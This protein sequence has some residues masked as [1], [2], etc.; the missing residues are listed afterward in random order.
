MNKYIVSIILCS[1]LSLDGHSCSIFY[2]NDGKSILAGN[3]EDWNDINTMIKFIPPTADKYGYFVFGLK[4]WG[5]DFCSWGGVN[6]QGVFYDWADIGT[7]DE[8][9][10]AKGTIGYN[11][12]LADKMQAECATVDEAIAIFKKYNCPGLG[13]AHILIGDRFGNSVVIEKTE[14]D[15]LLFIKNTSK[16]QIAT[17]FLNNYLN[18]P[19]IYRWVQCPRYELI[20]YELTNNDTISI[21]LFEK[22]LQHVGN[23]NRISPS[24]YSNIYDFVSGKMYIYNY[25]NFE[26]VLI[27]DIDQALK[28]GYQFYK[29][30]ELFSNLRTLLPTNNEKIASESVEFKWVGD[31]DT[32]ELWISTNADFDN[33]QIFDY[34]QSE[35]NMAGFGFSPFALLL[36]LAILA[37]NKRRS[38]IICAFSL[39]TM[40]G[41]E[42]YMTD[43]P[44][45]LSNNEHFKGIENLMPDTKYYWKVVAFNPQGF[46]TESNVKCFIMQ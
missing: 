20:E 27:L 38:I 31:A 1:I 18:D 19:E 3:S 29:L 13:G 4:D 15:S 16:Y 9:F 8:N 34:T 22:I 43:L 23:Q 36:I 37:L 33:P 35:I 26:E 25:F 10:H 28:R 24:V 2:A 42:K 21:P 39:M 45:T 11:G 14:N 6:D 44:S 5:I 7:R 40:L 12:I 41:C 30:P 46:N 32:Y 17:N